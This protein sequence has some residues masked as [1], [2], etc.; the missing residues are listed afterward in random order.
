LVLANLLSVVQV[1]HLADD[2]IDHYLEKINKIIHLAAQE[3]IP[4]TSG[5]TVTRPFNPA[6]TDRCTEARKASRK[7]FRDFQQG[8]I[9]NQEYNRTRK[10]PNRTANTLAK[11]HL[12]T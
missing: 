3:C 9:T 5:K 2:N 12:N 11:L 7:A 1:E 4:R 10:Q 6:W 8:K